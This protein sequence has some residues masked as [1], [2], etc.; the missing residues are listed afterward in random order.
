MHARPLFK[1]VELP[2][3]VL[4]DKIIIRRGAVD[5]IP[6]SEGRIP[7]YVGVDVGSISTNVAVLYFDK[8]SGDRN[9]KLLA[10][11]YT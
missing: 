3:L 8:N 6:V 9:W 5:E 4:N 2:P 7:A 10:K 11:K 1:D